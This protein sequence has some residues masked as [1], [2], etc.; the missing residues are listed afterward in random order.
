MKMG[1]VR[2]STIG[3]LRA[4]GVDRSVG[5]EGGGSNGN[6]NATQ[7]LYAESQTE[8]YV[9][10]PIENVGRASLNP[11]ERHHANQIAG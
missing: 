11:V 3:K 10:A 8:L 2:A 4:L 9:P 6:G 5:E 1:K 7:G